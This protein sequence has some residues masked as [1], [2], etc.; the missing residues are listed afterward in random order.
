MASPGELKGQNKGPCGYIMAAFD[1]HKKCARCREKKVGQDL[2]VLG[3]DC[4]ICDGF[5]DS[6]KERLANG[7]PFI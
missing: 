5:S 1:L 7:Y 3:N 4:L 2:C 6:Q